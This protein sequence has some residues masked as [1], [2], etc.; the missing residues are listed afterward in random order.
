MAI[1]SIIKRSSTGVYHLGHPGASN[2]RCNQNL[3]AT[4]ASRKNV[5][6]A[7]AQ[8]FCAKCFGGKPNPEAVEYF[9]TLA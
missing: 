4:P 3:C 7:P 6:A 8:M 1:R 2:V 5:E 9:F